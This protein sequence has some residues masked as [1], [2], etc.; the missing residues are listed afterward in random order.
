MLFAIKEISYKSKKFYYICFFHN[1][2]RIKVD[3]YD[4]LPLEETLTLHNVIILIKSVVNQ[5]QNHYY[6]NIFLETYLYQLAKKIMA[7]IFFDS[8]IMFRFD[9]V[10][11]IKEEFYNA[12][13]LKKY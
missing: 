4:S 3:S 1:F 10:K 7:K 2:A 12:K 11:V 13:R 5:N 9:E 8:I 6:Y